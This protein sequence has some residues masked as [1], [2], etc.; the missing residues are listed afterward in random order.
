MGKCE[1]EYAN[2]TKEWI[3]GHGIKLY[4][5]KAARLSDLCLRRI[6]TQETVRSLVHRSHSTSTIIRKW[7]GGNDEKSTINL[8]LLRD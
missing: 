2:S 5:G 6:Q 8:Q 1:F 3:W 7:N 4:R